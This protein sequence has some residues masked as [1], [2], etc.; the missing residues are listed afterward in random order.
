MLSNKFNFTKANLSNVAFPSKGKRAYYYDTKVRGLGVSLTDKGTITFI[1]YRKI[2]GKP[3]RITLGRF[4]DLSVEN[5]RGLASDVNAQIAHGKNPNQDKAKLK[6]EL[7]F[8]E[9]FDLYIER[10][11]KPHKKSWS[12]DCNQHRL[13]LCSWDKRKI[14]TIRKSDV[15]ILHANI[16]K[17]YGQY[18][19]NRVLS[20][21]STM[22]NKAIAW[23]WDGSNPAMGVKKFKEFSRERF[24]QG[25]ELPR[26]F[27]ALEEEE[28]RVLADFFMIS[29]LT[30]ARKSNVLSMCWQDINF[31]Q[32]TWRIPETKN[33]SSQLLPLSVEAI[34]ILE[35]R[36]KEKQNNWVFP[37]ATSKSG[38]LEEPKS[39]WKRILKKADLKDLRLHDLRRTLGSW[40]AAT[41]ANSYVIGKSLGHKTQQATAIYARLNIDPVRESMEKATK[42]MMGHSK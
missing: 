13:Y 3:E 35:A 12:N 4:P 2:D 22:F 16:G 41:G 42:A 24:L 1:V 33:G 20:Q 30:G 9:L 40:Q 39:A 15:E 11:A 21:L 7:T 8:K 14:S 26:F 17:N 38:H 34:A 23:G 28:N 25:D 29:L 10:Y 36:S 37:S 32:A 31:A 5:A 27:K 6:T 19:A 18:V